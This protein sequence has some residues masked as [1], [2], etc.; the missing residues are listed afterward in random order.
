MYKF[1]I[2]YRYIHYNGIDSSHMKDKLA[3]EYL[4]PSGLADS[5]DRFKLEEQDHSG[6]RLRD[7]IPSLQHLNSQLFK[8]RN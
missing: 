2:L 3:K 5:Q 4:L 7:T 6:Q 8:K 1:K